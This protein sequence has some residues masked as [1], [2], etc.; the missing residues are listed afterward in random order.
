MLQQHTHCA[1]ILSV[2]TPRVCVSQERN[3]R[4]FYRVLTEN[5]E[6]LMPVTGGQ[7]AREAC[8]CVGGPLGVC[9]IQYVCI[10]APVLELPRLSLTAAAVP[11][12]RVTF[13][14]MIKHLKSCVRDMHESRRRRQFE[15]LCLFAPTCPT[16][17][18][19]GKL[20]GMRTHTSQEAWSDLQE[21]RHP[22]G[23]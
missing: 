18:P 8:K 4:L 16:P 9:S 15:R 23:L 7:V 2:C 21:A 17:Q 12:A 10:E 5:F 13:L 3:E 11:Q 22:I 1:R 6:E 14:F 20:S 19:V